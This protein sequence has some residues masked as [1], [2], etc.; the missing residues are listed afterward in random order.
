M[1]ARATCSILVLQL[2][3]P[4]IIYDVPAEISTRYL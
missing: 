2:Y 4:G 1:V 3:I